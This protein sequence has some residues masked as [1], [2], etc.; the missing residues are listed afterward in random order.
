MRVMGGALLALALTTS[1]AAAP[2]AQPPETAPDL[3]LLNGRGITVDRAFSVAEAVAVT[4]DRI[5][6]VGTTARI[7]A[8]AGSA[9]R[10]IDLGGRALIPGLMDNHLH[11]A[12]GGHGVDLSRARSLGDVFAAVAARVR[13]TPAGGVVVSNSDWHEAQLRERRLPLRDDLDRVAP[14][15]P[16]VLVRGGHEFIVNSAALR[17]W[18]ID[19]RTAEPAGGRLTRYP[20][21]TPTPRSAISWSWNTWGWSRPW[22]A[23]WPTGCRHRS[24]CRSS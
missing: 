15:H 13:A 22:P 5:T 18:Q 14:R 4:G 23:A 11:S 6:A 12:G 24:R 2:A 19:E 1:W 20:D 8:L 3:V 21:S 17:R 9:T 10:R 7:R 16:V